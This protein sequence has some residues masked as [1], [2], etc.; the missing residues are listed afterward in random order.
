MNSLKQLTQRRKKKQYLNSK[1]D[2]K[3]PSYKYNLLN[4]LNQLIQ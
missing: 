2:N 1:M 3:V 4:E